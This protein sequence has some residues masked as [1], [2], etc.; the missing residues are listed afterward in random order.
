MSVN[1]VLGEIGTPEHL[2]ANTIEVWNKVDM[3]K[4]LDEDDEAMIE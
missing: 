4:G 1:K 3:I 2:N